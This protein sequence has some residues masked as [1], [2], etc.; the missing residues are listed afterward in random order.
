M[1][2]PIGNHGFVDSLCLAL[3]TL[4]FG[5]A[6]LD[7]KTGASGATLPGQS[8]SEPNPTVRERILEI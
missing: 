4:L 2:R 6:I 8:G 3:A 5:C 7:A 1:R